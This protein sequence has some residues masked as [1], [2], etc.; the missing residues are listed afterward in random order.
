MRELIAWAPDLATLSK[1]ANATGFVDKVVDPVTKKVISQSIKTTGTWV[2]SHGGWALNVVPQFMQP[3]GKTLTGPMGDY[4]EMAPVPGVWARLRWNDEAL[5]DRLEKFVA[6]IQAQGVT[7]Y[8]LVNIGTDKAPEW[9]WSFD[10][11]KSK[12]PAYLDQI[13]RM[14]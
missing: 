12:G 2:G 10:G 5:L 11:G 1:A 9:V 3:T 14:L 8:R 7:V 6:A 4:P 13:G